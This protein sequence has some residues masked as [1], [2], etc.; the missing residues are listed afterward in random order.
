MLFFIGVGVTWEAHWSSSYFDAKRDPGTR[1]TK[2]VAL[3]TVGEIPNNV[4]IS[5]SGERVFCILSHSC[6]FLFA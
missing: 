6:L 2:K 1:V 3:F 4:C 5:L